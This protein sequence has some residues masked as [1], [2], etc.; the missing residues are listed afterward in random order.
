MSIGNRLKIAIC[1]KSGLV[2][3]KLDR[4][5]TSQHSCVVIGESTAFESACKKLE[6][7]ARDTVLL[8]L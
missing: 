4:L 1:G 2:G 6:I 7:T 5:F 3:S 8:E